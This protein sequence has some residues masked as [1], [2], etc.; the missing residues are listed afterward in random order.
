MRWIAAIAVF[1]LLGCAP[2]PPNYYAPGPPGAPPLLNANPAFVQAVNRDVMWD[3]LV[4][5]VERY[6]QIDREQRVR[7]VG[8]VLTEGRIDTFPKTG[9]TLLEPWLP[10][11]VGAYNRLEGTLQSIRRRALIRVIPTEGGYLVDVAVFKELEDVLV[12]EYTPSGN[13]TFQ[14]RNDVAPPVDPPIEDI[15]SPVGWISQGRD[16]RLEQAIIADLYQRLS[17]NP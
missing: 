3:Q 15:S 4:A 9:A 5:V 14:S 10:D 12:P 11:A 7:Q 16:T 13:A 6:F 1:S 8:D 17:V 2:L